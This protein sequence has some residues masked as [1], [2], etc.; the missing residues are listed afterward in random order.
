MHD[1]HPGNDT[2]TVA[3]LGVGAFHRAHQAWYTHRA[4]ATG[5]RWTI[6]AFTQGPS[7]GSRIQPQRGIDARSVTKPLGTVML[8][9]RSPGR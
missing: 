9:V 2:P 4:A 3:H 1:G 5:E 6:A 8:C 7:G